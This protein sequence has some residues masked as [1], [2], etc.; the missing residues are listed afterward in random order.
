MDRRCASLRNIYSGWKNEK[1]S[2]MGIVQG[3]ENRRE[4][5]G[6]GEGEIGRGREK[7]RL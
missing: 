4:R 3:G 6:V 5:G 1:I 2:S 7:T